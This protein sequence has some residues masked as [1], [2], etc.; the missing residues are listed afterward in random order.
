MKVAKVRSIPR[1]KS[2]EWCDG[3][4]RCRLAVGKYEDWEDEE[5]CG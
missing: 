4:V 3:G 5:E 2:T 1:V